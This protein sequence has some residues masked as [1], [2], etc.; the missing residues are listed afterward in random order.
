MEHRETGQLAY[1]AYHQAKYSK[2]QRH[3]W[4]WWPDLD[5]DEQYAWREAAWNVMQKGWR[6]ASVLRNR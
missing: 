2:D 5:P 1:E 6:E 3:T 4:T